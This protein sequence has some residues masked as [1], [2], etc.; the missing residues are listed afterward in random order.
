MFF[1][2]DS[3]KDL[4]RKIVPQ[5]VNAQGGLYISYTFAVTGKKTS[6]VHPHRQTRQPQQLNCFLCMCFINEG[7]LFN[8]IC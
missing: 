8:N 5:Y 3:D 2:V 1:D 7:H 6:L 4:G